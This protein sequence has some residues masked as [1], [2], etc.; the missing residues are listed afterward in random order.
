MS[1]HNWDEKSVLFQHNEIVIICE[2]KWVMLKT[3]KKCSN[4]CKTRKS[5]LIKRSV[6]HHLQPLPQNKTF[7]RD[8]P[9][10]P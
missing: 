2:K 9:L 6:E 5:K 10:K 1:G 8:V 4:P 3:I 7:E